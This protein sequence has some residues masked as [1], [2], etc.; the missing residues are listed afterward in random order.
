LSKS[1]IGVKNF[2]NRTKEIV[3]KSMGGY[4]QCCGYSKYN[5]ALDLHHINPLE[6]DFSFGSVR[7]NPISLNKLTVELE[8]CILLCSN[9]HREIHGN[10]IKLPETYFNFDLNLFNKE[11][12]ITNT[13]V[14]IVNS[15]ELTDE[16]IYNLYVENNRNYRRIARKLGVDKESIKYR[17]E[18]FFHEPK[19]K[20]SN[21]EIYE[22]L[23]INKIWNM[24]R[25]A[26]NL[27]VSETAIRKRMKKYCLEND[28]RYNPK[29]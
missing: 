10:I 5:G 14:K 22:K 29:R 9:C 2:R 25:L 20:L 18:K 27:N 17:I 24:S 19:I 28:L 3:V 12:S 11:R 16:Q 1:S 8:K 21:Q 4:C 6:K 23:S 15:I 7:A 26:N 13:K